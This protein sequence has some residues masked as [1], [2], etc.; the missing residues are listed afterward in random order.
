MGYCGFCESWYCEYHWVNHQCGQM[1]GLKR[2]KLKED[3]DKEVVVDFELFDDLMDG[4]QDVWAMYGFGTGDDPIA[5]D[6]DEAVDEDLVEPNDENLLRDLQR[7]GTLQ[8]DDENDTSDRDVPRGRTGSVHDIPY[9]RVGV[10]TW[11]L[12]GLNDRRKTGEEYDAE[13]KNRYASLKRLVPGRDQE[14]ATAATVLPDI[15]RYWARTPLRND[16]ERPLHVPEVGALGDLLKRARR[17]AKHGVRTGGCTTKHADGCA[18]LR[19]A[20]RQIVGSESQ[21][22]KAFARYK[23]AHRNEHVVKSVLTGRRRQHPLFD[24]LEAVKKLDQSL[25]TRLIIEHVNQILRNNPWLDVLVLQEVRPDGAALLAQQLD[26]QFALHLG[27]CMQS[28]SG[29]KKL[30]Q[31]EYYP[32]IVRKSRVLDVRCY[33]IACVKP[34]WDG[35]TLSESSSEKSEPWTLEEDDGLKAYV[36]KGPINPIESY[37]TINIFWS[38]EEQVYRPVVVYEIDLDDDRKST[39]SIGCVHTSPGE[40]DDEWWRGPEYEQLVRAFESAGRG[41]YWLMGGDYYLSAEARVKESTT[42]N[43]SDL[44]GSIAQTL[45]DDYRKIHKRK[46]PEKLSVLRKRML[47]HGTTQDRQVMESLRSVLLQEYGIEIRSEHF[48][49]Q[50]FVDDFLREVGDTNRLDQNQTN[51]D[52]LRNVEELT[53]AKKLPTQWWISQT[54][55]GTNTHLH[56]HNFPAYMGGMMILDRI[57]RARDFTRARYTSKMRIADF[58]IY[59]TEWRCS[60]DAPSLACKLGL[61]DPRRPG[62][63]WY[64]DEDLK[65]SRYWLAMSDHFP[66]GGVFTTDEEDQLLRTLTCNPLPPGLDNAP[67]RR[68]GPVEQRQERFVVIPV[69]QDGDCFF[70]AL[71]A[72]GVPDS[73][74]EMRRHVALTMS[75]FPGVYV[76]WVDWVAVAQHY[77][78]TLIVHEYH[79]GEPEDYF[80][81]TLNPINPGD[82]RKT[83]HLRFIHVPG[84]SAGHMDLMRKV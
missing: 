42:E 83:I 70:H 53:F 12:H 76:G 55:S 31:R 68:S 84:E 36:Y 41:G 66:V 9:C 8:P 56:N 28:V 51:E 40:G 63:H 10:G 20:L 25:N 43:L 47:R 24:M 82:E 26:D 29:K 33:A 54:I 15:K 75:T 34:S 65:L 59:N 4:G 22:E 3:P 45:R 74:E 16:F 69:E 27:P 80:V 37:D 72:A 73:I 32:A 35:D 5:L 62:L 6:E 18:R 67:P 30:S 17:L 61:F 52:I 21:W 44:G 78:L 39:V 79:F 23:K 48:V 11:N 81:K 77:E 49:G 7:I 19:V 1:G 64:D 13:L 14:D 58:F 50:P 2:R 60:P 38:K 57:R 71:S 46:A